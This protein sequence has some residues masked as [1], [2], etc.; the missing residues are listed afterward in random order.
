ML[1]EGLKIA[2]SSLSSRKA[3]SF[4]TLSTVA[5]G[6]FAI[7]LAA[8]LAASGLESLKQSIEELGGARLILVEPKLAESAEKKQA[9]SDAEIDENDRAAL[10]TDMPHLESLTHYAGLEEQDVISDV[11]RSARA[12]F[13]ASDESFFELFRMRVAEGRPLDAEDTRGATQNCVVGPK[14]AE[15]VWSDS[16]VGHKLAIG[17]LHCRVVGRFADNNRWGTNFGFDWNNVVVVPFRTAALRLPNVRSSAGIA[18][19]TDTRSANDVVKRM[20][21]ARLERS[22]AGVDDF[23]IYD[24][25]QVMDRFETTFALLELLVALFSGIALVIGGVGIMNMMLV[26]VSERVRE[27]GIRKALG[28]TPANLSQQFLLESSLL[29]TAGGVFGVVLG[30]AAVF[31][32]G[33]LIRSSLSGW[34]SVY[35]IPAV[36]LALGASTL[37]GAAFGWLPARQAARLDPVEAIRR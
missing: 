9:Q 7:V 29:S 16:A 30:V 14:V 1:M 26:S 6:C 13:V 15:A 2:W 23:A 34:L 12:D 5:I 37:T 21:N 28:A 8:S 27:I 35:S 33:I 19:R 25:A 24:L 36:V 10:A 20:I 22:H 32:A 4:L 17:K 11:G 18:L 3:R 31:G